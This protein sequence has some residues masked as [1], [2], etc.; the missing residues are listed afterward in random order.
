[1]LVQIKNAQSAHKP[2]FVV[3]F[4]QM[5]K[6]IADVLL[7]EGFLTSVEKKMRK[8][9]KAEL[10]VLHVGLKYGS[11]NEAGTE[12]SEGVIRGIKLVSKPSRRMYASAKDIKPVMGGFGMAVL[13]T[14]RGVMSG[15]EARKQ[16]IG[17]ELL[18]EIW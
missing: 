18:F 9:K 17:G 16:N 10:P 1:M 5:K 14:S 12:I 4:S 7:G 15:K 2:D 13:S 8:T 6:A 3:Q 11:R